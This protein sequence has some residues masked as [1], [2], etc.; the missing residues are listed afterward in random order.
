M[1]RSVRSAAVDVSAELQQLPTS[2]VSFQLEGAWFIVGPTGLFVVVADEGDVV[3]AADRATQRAVEVRTQLARDVAW[4]PF[5]DALVATQH[6]E[7]CRTLPCITVPTHLLRY[8]LTEG[9]RAVDE[10]TLA[11]LIRARLSHHR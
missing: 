11:R 5:V 2:H 1:F 8:T 9:P 3:E 4:V 6:D 10:E 7:S